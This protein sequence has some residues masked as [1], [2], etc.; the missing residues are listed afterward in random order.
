MTAIQA[1]GVALNWAANWFVAFTFPLVYTWLGG[2]HSMRLKG[3]RLCH[4]CSPRLGRLAEN[5]TRY[6]LRNGRSFLTKGYTFLIF[7]AAACFFG[8]F[9][10]TSLPETRGRTAACDLTRLAA[11]HDMCW[12]SASLF[13]LACPGARLLRSA[14]CAHDPHTACRH[15]WQDHRRVRAHQWVPNNSPRAHLNSEGG[16]FQRSTKT[17]KR[18]KPG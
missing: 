3:G 8:R 7:V 9:T 2:V 10:Y 6:P 1:I 12:P 11:M 5:G 17:P 16:C 13:S 15:N 14:R 4:P 18:D